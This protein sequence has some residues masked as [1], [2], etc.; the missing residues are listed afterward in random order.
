MSIK[1]GRLQKA[2]LY[3]IAS[4]LFFAFMNM[5]VQLSGD[6]PT[7]QKSFFRNF[8]ALIVAAG[9]MIKEKESFIPK[10]EALFDVTMR[11]VCGYGGVLCNFYA[12]GKLNIADAS[13]LN[14]M[15]PFF[16][17]IFSIFLLKEKADKT[18]WLIILAAFCGA[19]FIIKPSFRN[20]EL[21]GSAAGFLGGICAGAAYTF[22]RRATKKGVKGCYIVFFF[23][24]FS[25]LV[26]LPIMI[27]GYAPMTSYQLLM[28]VGA[29][30]S[31]VGGQFCITAAYAHAPAKEVSIYD[32]TQIIFSAAI[33][34][35]VMGTLPDALSI[36]GY[37]IILS[38]AFAMFKYNNRG[39][40]ADG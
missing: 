15:S 33:G 37:V 14:K 32:Y 12:L 22:V 17:I 26:S 3:L 9:V 30:L 24:A 39:N 4:A 25:T 1:L 16:A 34:F 40:S 7:V 11:A 35:F 2:I 19:L 31:A 28:L 18:Q 27:F 5:F 29:G 10:K 20:A 8:F 23:S 13:L 36:V 6:L 38:A 21:V